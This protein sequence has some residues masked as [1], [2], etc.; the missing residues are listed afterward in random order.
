MIGRSGSAPHYLEIGGTINGTYTL[1][2]GTTYDYPWIIVDFQ[3]VELEDGSTY[4]NVPIIQAQYTGHEFVVFDA[5]EK[6]IAT[7]ATAQA[8]YYYVGCSGSTYTLL[9]L[10]TGDTI[11]YGD[12]TTAI[13][14]TPW[15]STYAVE[16]GE[17]CWA[18]SNLRQYLN[19]SGTE[20][21]IA[22]HDCDIA[23]STSLSGFMTYMPSIMINSLTPIKRTTTRSTYMGRTVD[24]TYDKF[25][26]AS[27]SE[28]NFKASSL[29][30]ADGAP[31][32]YYKQI[33]NSETPITPSTYTAMIRYR[34]D[35]TTR[36]TNWW[37]R[38]ANYGS[39]QQFYVAN[40]GI[41]SAALNPNQSYSVLP[42][43]ALI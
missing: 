41:T 6:T 8:G 36:A 2:D 29:F 14:K 39:P 22:Q 21:W 17:N 43:T 20:W 24:T 25:W 35:E 18:R 33:L 12:Y 16:Y 42:C 38:S 5:K 26:I 40:N 9:S 1:T 31:W 15:N 10:S 32:T 11:P 30:D 4:D 34:C 37:S 28:M 27:H 19:N 13:Y 23:P 3:T 7:E